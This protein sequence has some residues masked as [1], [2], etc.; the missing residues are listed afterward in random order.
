[1]AGRQAVDAA[2]EAY[3]LVVT[4]QGEGTDEGVFVD[5][6]VCAGEGEEA[7]GHGGKSE[8]IRGLVVKEG[9]FAGVVAGKE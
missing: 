5:S 7:G 2:K 1:M 6:T 9:A 4:G 8:G 3:G